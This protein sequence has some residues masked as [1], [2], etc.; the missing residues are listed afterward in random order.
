MNRCGFQ[1]T[2]PI[3]RRFIVLLQFI[4]A[5][6]GMFMLVRFRLDNLLLEQAAELDRLTV[7]ALVVITVCT[8]WNVVLCRQATALSQRSAGPAVLLLAV[9]AVSGLLPEIVETRSRASAQIARESEQQQRYREVERELQAWAAE[10]DRRTAQSRPL[11]AERAWE[12]LDAVSTAGYWDQEPDPLSLRALAV[13]R[14]ALT[15]RLM[16]VNAMVRGHRPKDETTRSLYLQ[17]FKERVEPFYHALPR[18]DWEI[19]QL[20]AGAG[21]DLAR[22]DAAALVADLAK[23]PQSGPSRFITLR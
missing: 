20:L 5:A 6:A 14:K 15:S 13:L 22:P 1:A 7:S 23:T 21:A 19:M 9:T 11:E 8:V 18:Q 4:V 17:F 16:D 12:L 3:M 10:L 2:K